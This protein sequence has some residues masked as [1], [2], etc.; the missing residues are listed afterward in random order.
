MN[1][2]MIFR[3]TPLKY[4]SFLGL[5]IVFLADIEFVLFVDQNLIQQRDDFW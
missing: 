2:I 3:Q 4:A 1:T 5:A